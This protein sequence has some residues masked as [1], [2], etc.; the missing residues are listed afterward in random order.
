MPW[1]TDRCNTAKAPM[2]RR[3]LSP[4]L[5]Y[6]RETTFVN[7]TPAPDSKYGVQKQMAV[8][9]LPVAARVRVLHYITNISKEPITV[10]PWLLYPAWRTRRRR[11]HPAPRQASASWS[12]QERQVLPRITL[13]TSLW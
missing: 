5:R 7:L 1:I 12:A 13:P 3:S 8:W 6:I 4:T 9:M 10:A 2:S 11:N